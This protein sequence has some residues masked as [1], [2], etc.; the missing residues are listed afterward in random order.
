V[1]HL[2]GG[3]DAFELIAFQTLK[4]SRCERNPALS[5]SCSASV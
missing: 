4:G 2:D 3:G 5:S 1:P